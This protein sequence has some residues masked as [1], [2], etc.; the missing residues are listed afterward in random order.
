MGGGN[1]AAETVGGKKD[2]SFLAET[3]LGSGNFP[4]L[5][6]FPVKPNRIHHVERER[7]GNEQ[8]EKVRAIVEEKK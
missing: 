6:S 2:A 1:K 3:E 8:R 4:F 5:F 7:V